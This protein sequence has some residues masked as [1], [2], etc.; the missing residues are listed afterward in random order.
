MI[1][2]T[3][4]VQICTYYR[5]VVIPCHAPKYGHNICLPITSWLLKRFYSWLD[6]VFVFVRA[7]KIR[8]WIALTWN[9]MAS[10]DPNKVNQTCVLHERKWEKQQK[11]TKGKHVGGTNL[12]INLFVS[13]ITFRAQLI[14]HESLLKIEF[15][16]RYT[17]WKKKG[18]LP[19]NTCWVLASL[20]HIN[21]Y[22]GD[23]IAKKTT[24][25]RNT[26]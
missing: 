6:P 16:S 15:A 26:S 2:I 22:S 1:S 5:S 20:L 12:S 10:P 8:D 19:R 17:S 25:N 9:W 24:L 23:P 11:Q 3:Q 4:Y 13:P 18:N 7:S 14:F 21:I